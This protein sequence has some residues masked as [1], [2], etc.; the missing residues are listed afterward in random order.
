MLSAA[1]TQNRAN[2]PL[3][4]PPER[5]HCIVQ[6]KLNPAAI[7]ASVM[8]YHRATSSPWVDRLAI[9]AAARSE[10]KPDAAAASIWR[11]VIAVESPETSS[12]R[13]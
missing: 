6:N 10:I 5:S 1:T 9:G 2:R 7:A 13:M 11:L 8:L 12:N 3:T 4:L